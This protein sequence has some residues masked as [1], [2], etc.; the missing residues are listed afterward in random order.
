MSRR[1]R[2]ARIAVGLAMSAA[3]VGLIGQAGRFSARAD[4]I[5]LIAPA[6]LA[7]GLGMAALAC[8]LSRRVIVKRLALVAAATLA[9]VAVSLPWRDAADDGTACPGDEL[10]LVQ[11]NVLKS[12]ADV[13]AAAAWIRGT[14]AD[15]VTLE[16]VAST[17]P[18]LALLRPTFPYVVACAPAL[19]CSTMILSRRPFL[20]SGG[21]AHGDPDNRKGLSAAWAVLPSP[22]GNF[23]LVAA[24]LDR[25]WPFHAN[26]GNVAQLAAFVRGRGETS[27]LA[28]DFN[29][30]PPSF[31]LR[32]LTDATGLRRARDIRSWPALAGLP[33]LLAI[34][35]VFAGQRWT[36]TDIERGP[37]LGSDHYPLLVTLKLRAA[38]CR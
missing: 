15:A 14:D 32:Q 7:A 35:H 10:R 29:L 2:A 13:R 24:H 37:A 31:Q 9:I 36:I 3:A 38:S 27:L 8:A 30:P 28:G 18:I 5:N 26:P 21:L 19:R 34:D 22:A 1:A 25:P 33:P 4:M 16:E 11:F 6:W 20:Q 17:L 23:T 12:N